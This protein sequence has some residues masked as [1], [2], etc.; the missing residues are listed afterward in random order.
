MLSMTKTI[1][2][3]DEAYSLAIFIY[4]TSLG[5]QHYSMVRRLCQ[6]LD[7]DTLT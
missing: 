7:I 3:L 2:F 4:L 5:S 6:S 1:K